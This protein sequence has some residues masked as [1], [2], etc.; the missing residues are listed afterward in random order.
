MLK[1]VNKRI[2]IFF[3]YEKKSLLCS[4]IKTQKRKEKKVTKERIHNINNINN[5]NNI[6]DDNKREEAG[7]KKDHH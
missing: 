4:V 5:I 3:S 1:K 7:K 2:P 6:D